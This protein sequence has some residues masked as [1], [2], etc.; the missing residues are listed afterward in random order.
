MTP[1]F[2]D[3]LHLGSGAPAATLKLLKTFRR[4]TLSRCRATGALPLKPG[5]KSDVLTKRRLRLLTG[6]KPRSAL[7]LPSSRDLAPGPQLNVCVTRCA[8]RACAASH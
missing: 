2:T 6:T 5:N 4:H 8:Q 3:C 7:H 1:G